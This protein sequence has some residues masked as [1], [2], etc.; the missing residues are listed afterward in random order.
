MESQVKKYFKNLADMDLI[1]IKKEKVKS[2]FNNILVR[3]RK[4]SGSAPK[5]GE[6]T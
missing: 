6:I 3:F 4:N 5:L 1:R 2:E